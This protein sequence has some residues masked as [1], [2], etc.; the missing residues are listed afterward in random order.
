MVNTV[1]TLNLHPR[2]SHTSAFHAHN[3]EG[4]MPAKRQG[5][6]LLH[7]TWGQTAGQHRQ[8]RGRGLAHGGALN[9]CVQ[10]T[11]R[12]YTPYGYWL[13]SSSVR[14]LTTPAA[15]SS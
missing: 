7:L 3:P 11:A 14:H 15:K 5:D 1:L 12:D 2:L 10:D 4:T 6:E 8:P 13:S 9:F